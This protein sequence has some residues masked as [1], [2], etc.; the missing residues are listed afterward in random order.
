MVPRLL[1][2]VLFA[3]GLAVAREEGGG[4]G[5]GGGGLAPAVPRSMP[6]RLEQM[7]T[8]LNLTKDQ[9]KQFKTILDAGCKDV[10]GLRK[11]LAQGKSAI[12]AAVASGKGADDLKKMVEADALATSQMIEREF[13][14][15]AELYKVLDDTQKKSPAIQR[16][17]NMMSGLFQNKNWN[18]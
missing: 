18:Q 13:R 8:S 11:Q 4:G 5:G 3:G 10:E 1:L 15:F 7:T 16:L 14:A 6:T 9:S 12:K 2:G 17:I